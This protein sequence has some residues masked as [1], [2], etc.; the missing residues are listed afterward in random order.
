LNRGEPAV[1]YLL[2]LNGWK[3]RNAMLAAVLLQIIAIILLFV[4]IAIFAE[5]RFVQWEKLG[6]A[7]YCNCTQ[8]IGNMTYVF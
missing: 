5:W 7:A 4:A 8:R 1:A 3:K 2:Q 6:C